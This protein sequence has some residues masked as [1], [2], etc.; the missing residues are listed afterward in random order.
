LH[1]Y[2]E[3]HPNGYSL[4]KFIKRREQIFVLANLLFDSDKSF[5]DSTDGM[6]GSRKLTTHLA[7]HNNISII[8]LDAE[9]Y[10]QLES[11]Q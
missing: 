11:K 6:I 8:P 3:Q 9:D 1:D 7:E 2:A 10:L 5:G 4:S